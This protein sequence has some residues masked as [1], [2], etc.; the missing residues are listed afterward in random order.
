VNIKLNM[1][2]QQALAP[3]AANG[4]LGCVRHSV[5][6]RSRELIL[7]LSAGEATPRVLCP[8]LG[9]PVQ[10]RHGLAGESNEGPQR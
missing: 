1:G 9:S 2:Q 10:E 8:V 4:T 6:S 7:P 5:T 3:K